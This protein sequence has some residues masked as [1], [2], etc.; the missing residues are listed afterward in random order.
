MAQVIPALFPLD[1]GSGGCADHAAGE[2]GA[3]ALATEPA[4]GLAGDPWADLLGVEAGIYAAQD[5]RHDLARRL[6]QAIAGQL[7][8]ALQAV[9]PLLPGRLLHVAADGVAPPVN[10]GPTV[11]AIG[12]NGQK[13]MPTKL[14][15][16]REVEA[17]GPLGHDP[18][19][20]VAGAGG[21][22]EDGFDQIGAVVLVLPDVALAEAV[23]VELAQVAVVGVVGLGGGHRFPVFFDQAGQDRHALSA[24]DDR[25]RGVQGGP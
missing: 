5:G 17:A 18:A 20:V 1:A 8:H 3:R 23:A 6:G 21:F 11:L 4:A 16:R 12:R 9:E 13:V 24:D 10:D 14:D 25:E 22:H 15:I 7:V 2:L 19:L